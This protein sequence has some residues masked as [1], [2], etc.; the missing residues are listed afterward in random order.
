M[1]ITPDELARRLSEAARIRAVLRKSTIACQA[2]GKEVLEERR[3]G[4]ER[5][6]RSGS[7]RR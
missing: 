7:P 6:N 2:L 1:K 3:R 5:S 4:P